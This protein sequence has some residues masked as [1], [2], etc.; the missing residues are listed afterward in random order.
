M[1]S[2]LKVKTWDQQIFKLMPWCVYIK[3]TDFFQMYTFS[4]LCV[5]LEKCRPQDYNMLSWPYRPHWCWYRPWQAPGSTRDWP[6]GESAACQSTTAAAA[7][8]TCG[9]ITHTH[10]HFYKLF[11]ELDFEHTLLVC[12]CRTALLHLSPLNW[13]ILT[14]WKSGNVFRCAGQSS[15]IR[16]GLLKGRGSVSLTL[17]SD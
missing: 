15:I 6:E 10:A 14:F 11:L 4:C 13:L 3:M 17:P 8:M 12:V 9:L 2:C 1:T 7:G 16:G 5:M